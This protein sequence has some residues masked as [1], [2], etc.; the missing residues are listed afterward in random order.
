MLSLGAMD[1]GTT[2]LERAFQLARSGDYV[3]VSDIK[4]QL[5]FEGYSASQVAGRTL[6]KQLLALIR[7]ARAKEPYLDMVGVPG[8]SL[9][10]RIRWPAPPGS[11][12]NPRLSWPPEKVEALIK[13]EPEVLAMWREATK[14][15]GARNDIR[16]NPTEVVRDDRGKAYALSRLKREAP[17]LF[18][19][20]CAGELSANAAAIEAGFRKKPTP[21]EQVT[22]LIRKLSAAEKRK[23]RAEETGG[24]G[25]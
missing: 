24:S 12:A 1:S 15:Q 17:K 23:L 7:E 21:F 13:D 4:K 14:G 25:R 16:S 2:A 11:L 8:L 19:A 9:D 18:Q 20:V 10:G 3:S 5:S 22:K 6:T